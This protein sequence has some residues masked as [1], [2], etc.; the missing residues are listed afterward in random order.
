[1]SVNSEW[2][3]VG[4]KKFCLHLYGSLK[5]NETLRQTFRLQYSSPMM[6]DG[7]DLET[8][9]FWKVWHLGHHQWAPAADGAPIHVHNIL[10]IY[11]PFVHRL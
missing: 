6:E 8:A 10:T 4:M 3:D 1:M 5:W 9:L 7:F 11:P 2:Y